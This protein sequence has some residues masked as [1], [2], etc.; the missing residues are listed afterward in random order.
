[1]QGI[2]SRTF[3]YEQRNSAWITM[4]TDFISKLL[5]RQ[6][7]TASEED[8]EVTS[9]VYALS[10]RHPGSS[11][12]ITT[13]ARMT[14]ISSFNDGSIHNIT[15]ASIEIWKD[16]GWVSFE[17]CFDELFSLTC[18]STLDIEEKCIEMLALFFVGKLDNDSDDQPFDLGPRPP[19]IKKKTVKPP[20]PPIPQAD[21]KNTETITTKKDIGSQDTNDDKKDPDEP[22]FDW[23]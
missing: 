14:I 4:Y 22:D 21:I 20:A 8:H 13:R 1:M 2:R 3:N 19:K 12:S 15:A 17:D 7:S 23:I 9:A 11:A 5:Y 10:W 6:K 16:A 18:T